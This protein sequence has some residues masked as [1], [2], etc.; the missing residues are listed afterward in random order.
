[1]LKYFICIALFFNVLFAVN[2]LD[3]EQEFQQKEIQ[4][5]F[6]TYNKAM[7]KFNYDLYTYFLRPIVISYKSI[8]PS[9]VRS[10]IKNVFDTTRS[11]AR[12]LNHLLTFEFKKAGE[13]FGRFCINV[14]F[15]FGLLDS[16]SK[17][18]LKSY[19]AD[20]GTTLGKWGVGSGSHL[21]LP[22]LGPSNIRDT[23]A[24]PVNWFMVPEGYI[25]NFWLGASINVALKVNDL[26]F[27]YEKL[28]DIYQ[29]SVDYYTF[30]RDA[31]EQRRWD[32]IK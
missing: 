13:E 19:E 23:L 24:L 27:E 2:E 15:G 1:M 12:I 31:Y 8:T 18:H 10:G 3:F 30:I 28:D 20:F 17:T 7:S 29:N 21:V 6:Y 25:E 16:A 9:F 22:F 11:P 26:S 5:S 32:L 4:D 14:I